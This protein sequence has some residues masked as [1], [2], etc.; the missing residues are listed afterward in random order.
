[1]DLHEQA[2]LS[3]ALGVGDERLEQRLL[4]G[5]HLIRDCCRMAD[6]PAWVPRVSVAKKMMDQAI[7][8]GVFVPGDLELVAIARLLD[9]LESRSSSR[10]LLY[11]AIVAYGVA[12]FREVS[13]DAAS[14][15]F[16]IS[17]GLWTPACSATDRLEATFYR[18]LVLIR[19]GQI[20]GASEQ[21]PLQLALQAR[22]ALNHEFVALAGVM[23]QNRVMLTGNLQATIVE[24]EKRLKRLQSRPSSR[25]EGMLLNTLAAAYGRAG[26]FDQALRH[27]SRMLHPRYHFTVRLAALNLSGV[28]LILLGELDAAEAAFELLLLAPTAQFRRSGWLGLMDLHARRAERHAFERAYEHM[29]NQ[30]LTPDAKIHFWH[31]SGRGWATFGDVARARL[32]YDEAYALARAYGF[33]YEIFETE[34]HIATLPDPDQLVRTVDIAPEVAA[35]ITALRDD[36]A[37]EIAACMA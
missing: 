3:A 35:H 24:G 25:A 8:D 2:F 26:N 17:D 13:F 6:D 21:V 32:A 19:G 16:E 30:P 1:M 4:V 18:G 12:L 36:H 23:R 22:A 29:L 7:I 27:A 15:A 9:A 11:S 14:T 31:L 33:G 37:G 34:D 5:F 10:A 20:R 28:T